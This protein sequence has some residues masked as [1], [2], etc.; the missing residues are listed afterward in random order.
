MTASSMHP[1]LMHRKIG[2]Q[3]WLVPSAQLNVV[4]MLMSPLHRLHRIVTLL[5][6]GR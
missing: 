4:S 5:N 2:N 3:L 1:Q 6:I